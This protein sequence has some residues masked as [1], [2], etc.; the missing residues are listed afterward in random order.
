[1]SDHEVGRAVSSPEATDDRTLVIERE[2]E[3]PP[4]RVFHAWTDP[5][6]VARWWGPEGY[7]VPS[8]RMDIRTG[9]S[10]RTTMKGP[11]GESHTVSGVYREIVPPRR[12]VFTWGW[13]EDGRRGHET[14]V[15]VTLEP[16]TLGTRLRLIQRTFQGAAQRDNHKMGWAA[17]FADLARIL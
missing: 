4:E 7:S 14:V 15:E 17:S 5:A 12:L 3:A 10:Y 2:F 11:N 16:S 9:G 8:H 13:E 6:T 1:M